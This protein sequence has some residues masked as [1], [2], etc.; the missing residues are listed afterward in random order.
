MQPERVGCSVGTYIST[1]NIQ[2]NSNA[3]IFFTRHKKAPVKGLGG[4]AYLLIILTAALN[5]SAM[6]RSQAW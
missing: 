6:M 4:G 2:V 5:E 1:T 3:N